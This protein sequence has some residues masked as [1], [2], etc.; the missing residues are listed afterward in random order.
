[1]DCGKCRSALSATLRSPWHRTGR[2]RGADGNRQW[3]DLHGVQPGIPAHQV[4]G[5][6]SGVVPGGPQQSGRQTLREFQGVTTPDEQRKFTELY[7]VQLLQSSRI[8]PVSR[9][10]ISTISGSTQFSEARI[11]TLRWRSCLDSTI[12]CRGKCRRSST[13][14]MS[15]SRPSM[16]SSRTSAIA[17]S[18]IFGGRCWSTST[19]S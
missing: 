13:T 18:T 16:S 6:A 9:V 15:P 8:D 10:C 3:Q 12:R 19:G 5:C 14:P 1:M 4:R 11:S 2:G 17:P 7:N